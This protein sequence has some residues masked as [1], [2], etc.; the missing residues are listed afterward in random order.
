MLLLD[1]P[2]DVGAPGEL[3]DEGSSPVTFTALAI[4]KFWWPTFLLS[5]K[6]FRA[7]WL[8]SASARSS[9][10]ADF[11]LAACARLPRAADRSAL[12]L[13]TTKKEASPPPSTASSRAASTRTEGPVPAAAGGGPISRPAAVSA[14]AAAHAAA[15]RRGDRDRCIGML[16]QR[17]TGE[18]GR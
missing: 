1:D 12:S 8:L 2:G 13:R 14:A 10:N 11:V 18:S 9:V 7:R 15:L 16:L 17:R 6:E 4:Q 5:R 3:L